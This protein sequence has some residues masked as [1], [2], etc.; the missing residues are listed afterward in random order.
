MENFIFCAVS[1]DI[2]EICSISPYSVRM[3][4]NAGQNN[5]N[6][7]YFWSDQE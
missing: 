1:F 5:F 7:P 2:M 4:E 6:F 3:R